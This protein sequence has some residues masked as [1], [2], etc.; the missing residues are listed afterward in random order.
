MME[1]VKFEELIIPYVDKVIHD[2]GIITYSIKQGIFRKSSFNIKNR[3]KCGVPF[4]VSTPWGEFR[5][6]SAAMKG[7][8]LSWT[9]LYQRCT[10]EEDGYKLINGVENEEIKNEF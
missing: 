3:R 6:I 1:Q 8:G 7:T 9:Q 4:A 2:N 10:K 5:S